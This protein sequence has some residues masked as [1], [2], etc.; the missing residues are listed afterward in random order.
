MYDHYT[1]LIKCLEIAMAMDMT[2][3]TRF[4]YKKTIILPEP[5]NNVYRE[6]PI[7]NNRVDISRT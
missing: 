2:M 7:Q 3:N 6:L 4:F 1:Q 5:Q